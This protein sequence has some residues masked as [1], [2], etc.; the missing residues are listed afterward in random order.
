MQEDRVHCRVER[1]VQP[2]PKRKPQH[3]DRNETRRPPKVPN[4]ISQI[5]REALE[6][7]R[8]ATHRHGCSWNW[9]TSSSDTPNTLAIRKATSRD[10]EYLPS[11]MALTVWR[12]TPTR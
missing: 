7:A 11:S 3:A 2:E 10:G 6:P 9:N 4:P 1:E 12:V 5:L 8:D